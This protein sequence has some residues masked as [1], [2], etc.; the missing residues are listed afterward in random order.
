MPHRSVEKSGSGKLHIAPDFSVTVTSSHEQ[1]PVMSVPVR[2]TP[3]GS[4]AH[5]FAM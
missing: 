1:A 4:Q 3:D 5:L 2:K